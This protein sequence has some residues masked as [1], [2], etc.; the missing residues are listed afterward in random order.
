[1]NT[2]TD[3]PIPTPSPSPSA[4]AIEARKDRLD[5]KPSLAFV[6]AHL[7]IYQ[8]AYA[9]LLQGQML[10]KPASSMIA[11]GK[12]PCFRDSSNGVAPYLTPVE[13]ATVLSCL[14]A[15]L[16]TLSR[17]HTVSYEFANK[18]A[19]PD[20]GED[21]AFRG[22]KEMVPLAEFPRAGD[23]P[24]R[25]LMGC[26]GLNGEAIYLTGLPE[27]V[28]CNRKAGWFYQLHVFL[29]EFFHTCE[30]SRRKQ[31]ERDKV[32]LCG[33]HYD[34]TLQTW[35]NRWERLFFQKVEPRFVSRYAGTF[36]EDINE[37]ITPETWEAREEKLEVALAEQMCESFVAYILGVAPNDEG[38]TDFKTESFGNS[39]EA[40]DYRRG[41]SISAN[42]K[43]YLIHQ[44]CTA[45]VLS[46]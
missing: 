38:W 23:H 10:F 34:F 16:C 1:M 41:F 11:V 37:K 45:K 2:P 42:E 22:C 30:L 20:F 29:H 35:W 26:A 12:L 13:V 27:C 43:W 25:L 19:V 14:P 32:V 6:A 7:P 31:G 5:L 18:V 8:E 21:G 24:S 17:L 36:A 44:L 28:S 3:H 33:E 4:E 40:A 39:T 9:R 15:S 46:H